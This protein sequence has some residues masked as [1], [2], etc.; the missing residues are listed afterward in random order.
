VSDDHEEETARSKRRED[1]WKKRTL[2]L[3]RNVDQRVEADNRVEALRFEVEVD[4][5]M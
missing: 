3:E 5:A 4:D 2:I 1:S